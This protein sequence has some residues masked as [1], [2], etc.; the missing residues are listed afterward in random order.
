[1]TQGHLVNIFL[2]FYVFSVVQGTINILA[3]NTLRIVDHKFMCSVYLLET[4][5]VLMNGNIVLQ[6]AEK[7][8]C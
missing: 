7:H 1:M 2:A 3:S 5:H 8:F 4:V 6:V